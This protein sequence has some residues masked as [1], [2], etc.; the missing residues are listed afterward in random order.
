MGSYTR[1]RHPED[2]RELQIKI[3][4]D[5]CALYDVGDRI[6]WSANRWNV[7]QH[8]DGV[9][10][11]YSNMGNDD[12]VIINDCIIVGVEKRLECP[13]DCEDSPDWEVYNNQSYN[14]FVKYN[15][16]KADDS[17]WSAEDW[18]YL[19]EINKRIKK[20]QEE[21]AASISHLSAEE[22]LFSTMIGPI[23]RNL[24]YVGMARKLFDI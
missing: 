22:R 15:I 8:I 7:G 1:V 21:F 18:E 9:Y 6:E 3:G 19:S 16:Q 17:L 5:V 4:D 10:S 23:R 13:E 24:D 20:E 12:F 14:L 11:S 2:G